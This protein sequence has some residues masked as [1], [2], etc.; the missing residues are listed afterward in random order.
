MING[1]PVSDWLS[2]LKLK[3]EQLVL[4]EQIAKVQNVRN[5]FGTLVSKSLKDQ[6]L[7]ET[8]METMKDL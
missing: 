8:L 3:G 7:L 4:K 6:M 1:Y 5:S 2:D